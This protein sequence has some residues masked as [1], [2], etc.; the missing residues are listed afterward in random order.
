MDSG[1]AAAM[2]FGALLREDAEAAR[3]YDGYSPEQRRRLLLTIQ[4]T[5][6]EQ[7]EA[8]VARMRVRPCFGS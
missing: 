2:A 1:I 5:P 7:M 6:A 8:L 3:I 4:D